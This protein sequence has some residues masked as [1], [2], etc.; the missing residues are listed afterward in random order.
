MSS[1]AL[2]E[3]DRRRRGL[4]VL[5]VGAVLLLVL[6]FLGGYLAL[7]P[8]ASG[9]TQGSP[10]A[11]AR[12]SASPSVSP[13]V[14]DGTGQAVSQPA[15]QGPVGR[16]E[17]VSRGG[18]ELRVS[19]QVLGRVGPG[20]PATLVLT[21]T[22]PDGSAVVLTGATARVTD[23]TS[24]RACSP[25]W[26]DVGSFHGGRALGP[27]AT[28]TITLRITFADSPTVNQDGCKGARYSYRYQVEARQA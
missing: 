4:L 26:Y 14:V 19:S 25:G 20:T 18:T 1:P 3:E 23:V 8:Q 17:A 16:G 27:H 9:A 22:N 13:V 6:G 11:S 7:R 2:H 24:A 12:P 15:R 21:I 28:T 10:R 5:L